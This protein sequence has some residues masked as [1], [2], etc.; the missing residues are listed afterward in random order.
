MT[1]GGP[2][3]VSSARRLR[4]D[5][6][7]RG[8]RGRPGRVVDAALWAVAISEL[9]GIV[10]LSVV[11][12]PP[13][14]TGRWDKLAH[15]GAYAAM[16]AAFLLA[17][18]WRP[19][20]GD[21]P[22]PRAGTVIVIAAVALGLGLELVQAPVTGRRAEVTDVVSDAVGIA[23]AWTVWRLLRTDAE[24]PRAWPRTRS[25]CSPPRH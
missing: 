2:T 6:P 16:T 21:G 20:R 1:T 25:S 15:A 4:P 7:G 5:A 24:R 17:V 19:G 13:V 18:V 12:H 22:A 9:V 23:V 8:S 11:G 3:N 14:V 10:V